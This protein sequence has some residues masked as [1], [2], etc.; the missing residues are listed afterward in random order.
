MNTNGELLG[1]GNLFIP[2]ASDLFPLTFKEESLWR[3]RKGPKEK[4]KVVFTIYRQRSSETSLGQ[5]IHDVRV[6]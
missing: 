1:M 4:L 2:L 3:N 6:N 5:S